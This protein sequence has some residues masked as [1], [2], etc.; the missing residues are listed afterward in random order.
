MKNLTY[1]LSVVVFLMFFTGCGS[2]EAPKKEIIRPVKSMLVGSAAD[3]AGQGFPATTKASQESEISFR[4][5]GPLI[6][7]NV[8]EGAKVTKGSVIAEIDPRDYR[9]AEQSARARYEQ[10]KAE[11]DR[12]MRLWKKG[13]VAKNDY[14]RKKAA[15][16][17]AKA[18]W[19]DAVNYLKDTKL[20]APFTGFYGAKLVDVGQDVRSKQPIT[21]LSNLSVIEVA[22]TIPEQLAVKFR[23]FDSYDVVFDTYPDHTF[24][25]TLKEM[26]KVPTPEGF[27]LRLYLEHKNDPNNTKQ[28]K[29]SAGMSC[30]VNIK[31]KNLKQDDMQMVIPLAAVIEGETDKT[32]SVWILEGTGD[33]YTVKKQH[34]NLDGFAGKDK[35]KVKDGLK[36]GEQI[37]VAGAK[38]LVEGQKVK[39][40]DQKAF[41]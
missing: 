18:A 27:P 40:L 25:A 23:N 14:D 31:L 35:V 28:P 26:G 16:L 22:T 41:N 20:R 17:E 34:I 2:E 15:Y 9:I 29:V 7:T 11:A 21:T 24:K 38:R 13:S 6:K 37:V 4:V 33:S 10:T 3:L 39:I 12:Y 8:V 1:L 5:G 19:E 32:P 30:R 36:A